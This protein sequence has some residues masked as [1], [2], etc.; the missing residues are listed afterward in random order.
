MLLL[1]QMMSNLFYGLKINKIIINFPILKKKI[2]KTFLK[3]N[4]DKYK[5]WEYFYLFYFVVTMSSKYWILTRE[6]DI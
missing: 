4:W 6:I 3:K 5:V 2:S 1:I